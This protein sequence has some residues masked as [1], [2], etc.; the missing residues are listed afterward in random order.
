[1]KQLTMTEHG[2]SPFED[3]V[4]KLKTPVCKAFRKGSKIV[5]V[6]FRPKGRLAA[7]EQVAKAFPKTIAQHRG[8]I[9]AA[10][11]PLVNAKPKRVAVLF[12][13]GPAAGGHNVIVGVK[14]ALGKRSMLLGVRNGPK[15]LLA[16]DLFEIREKELQQLVNTGGFDFLGTDR[17]KIKTDEQLS[18]VR[19]VCVK[20][21]LDAII[22]VG[23]DDS[24]TNAAVLAEHLF[25][26]IKPG[27]PESGVQVIGVPKTMDGDLQYAKLLPISFGFDTAT[28]IY[29]ELAGNILQDTRSS[30][31]YWHFI[32][33][34]GRSASNV[35]LEVAL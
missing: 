33:L 20:Y 29:A 27:R 3:E 35:A 24:N 22:I 14:Q 12:S 2:H 8:A 18:Q 7:K 31:K 32:R 25:S 19:A 30:R 4:R 6:S 17:T 21:N 28:R 5:P 10:A 15:G 9:L 11:K 34:M 23:G 26:G 1:M 16:G 13:G